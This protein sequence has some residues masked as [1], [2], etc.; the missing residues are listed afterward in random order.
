MWRRPCRL[1]RLGTAPCSTPYDERKDYITQKNIRHWWW[2]ATF[3]I[4]HHR[5]ASRKSSTLRNSQPVH[6]HSVSRSSAAHPSL[7]PHS[8]TAVSVTTRGW[9]THDRCCSTHWGGSNPLRVRS[10]PEGTNLFINALGRNKIWWLLGIF[11]FRRKRK[12]FWF[13]YKLGKF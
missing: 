1:N 3:A 6:V 11:S 8:V 7:S 4:F 10:S 9:G 12:T 5:V 2:W 13:C